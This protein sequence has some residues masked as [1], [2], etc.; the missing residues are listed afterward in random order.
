MECCRGQADIQ[1]ELEIWR[2][3]TACRTSAQT[4][5][6]ASPWAGVTLQ[7]SIVWAEKHLWG[8]GHGG[9]GNDTFIFIFRVLIPLLTFPNTSIM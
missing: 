5:A 1:R 3:G 7:G 9:S 2:K 6:R 8:K 4:R